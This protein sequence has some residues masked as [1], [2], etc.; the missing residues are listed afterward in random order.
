MACLGKSSIHT[1]RFS[2]RNISLLHSYSNASAYR[3]GDAVFVGLKVSWSKSYKTFCRLDLSSPK[4]A[5]VMKRDESYTCLAA[6]H[7]GLA[8]QSERVL[9]IG[10]F[11]LL[12][13]TCNTLMGKWKRMESEAD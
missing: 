3:P 10:R 8:V 5:V 4:R 13:K 9:L 6:D 1:A 7:S 2:I 12:I 11:G